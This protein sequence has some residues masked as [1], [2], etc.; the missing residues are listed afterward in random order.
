MGLDGW[1]LL[2]LWGKRI[3]AYFV[4]QKWKLV[5][6]L[7]LHMLF[8]A[9]STGLS[10]CI[11]SLPF[12]MSVSVKVQSLT[13]ALCNDR[14]GTMW[15]FPC[16]TLS[17]CRVLIHYFFH[18]KL[19]PLYLNNSSKDCYITP[20]KDRIYTFRHFLAIRLRTQKAVCAQ[21]CHECHHAVT[22]WNQPRLDCWHAGCLH[23][24]P[25]FIS[26]HAYPWEHHLWSDCSQWKC[27]N[28]YSGHFCGSTLTCAFF[29]LDGAQSHAARVAQVFLD[30]KYIQTLTWTFCPESE[31][32]ISTY[33]SARV[34]LGQHCWAL[35]LDNQTLLPCQCLNLNRLFIICLK[36]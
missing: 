25:S 9:T 12:E 24:C 1:G 14:L 19:M 6:L 21:H 17:S 31:I 11:I 3:G 2:L 26:S 23:E 8:V 35:R 32:I 27:S 36:M 30:N 7:S 22:D 28:L 29:Q 20:H 5:S 4:T 18:H 16:W 33:S 15:R 10:N 34:F 13:L